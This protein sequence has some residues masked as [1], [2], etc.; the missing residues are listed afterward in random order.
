MVALPDIHR[1]FTEVPHRFAE[2]TEL[3]EQD[4][5][6]SEVWRALR[7]ICGTAILTAAFGLWLVPSEAADPAMMLIKLAMSLGMVWAGT[8]CLTAGGS[9]DDRPQIEIDTRARRLHVRKAQAAPQQAAVYDLDELAE[10][11]L[12]DRVLTARDR[13]GRQIVSLALQDART[14]RTLREALSLAA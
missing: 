11:S 13:D 12:R 14:E 7:V 10:L 8:L 6:L 2:P 3:P 4:R 5:L 9:E 1:E